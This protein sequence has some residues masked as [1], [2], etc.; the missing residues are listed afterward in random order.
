M[1]EF[2]QRWLRLESF[3]YGQGAIQSSIIETHYCDE[4]W[5]KIWG[6]VGKK[7]KEIRNKVFS[8]INH[9]SSDFKW[10]WTLSIGTNNPSKQWKYEKNE[11]LNFPW[12]TETYY[13]FIWVGFEFLFIIQ[14]T[15]F[16]SF[17]FQLNFNFPTW[18]NETF[19]DENRGKRAQ[20][21]E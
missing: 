18:L 5:R 10:F 12:K 21:V 8:Y 20:L 14:L 7:F 3:S 1:K 9:I 4:N 2:F 16:S 15:F 19:H 6:K 13:L 11:K 17:I